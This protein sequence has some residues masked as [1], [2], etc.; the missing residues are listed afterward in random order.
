MGVKSEK[1]ILDFFMVKYEKKIYKIFFRIF[2]V[3][4]KVMCN[5]W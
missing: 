4:G 5:M 3:Y 1:K 2:I